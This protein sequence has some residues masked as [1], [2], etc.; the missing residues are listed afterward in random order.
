[1]VSNFLISQYSYLVKGMFVTSVYNKHHKLLD[2]INLKQF[3]ALKDW[4]HFSPISYSNYNSFDNNLHG[5][6]TKCTNYYC[7]S[8]AIFSAQLCVITD[9]VWSLIAS[10]KMFNIRYGTIA[11]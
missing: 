6:N 11:E 4:H 5:F 9:D 10:C 7:C 1:M 3:K 2:R 8:V